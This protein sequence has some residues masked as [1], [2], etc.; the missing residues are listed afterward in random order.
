MQAAGQGWSS[1]VGSDAV[2]TSTSAA[3]VA[4]VPQPSSV[5]LY[6]DMRVAGVSP[7]SSL[8]AVDLQA[9][10]IYRSSVVY[11]QVT[12]LIIMLRDEVTC[13]FSVLMLSVRQQEQLSAVKTR[14]TNSRGLFT[15]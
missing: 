11:Q 3:A 15:W 14:S 6:S 10:A 1:S 7:A 5:Q 4:S 12:T 2:T 9:S 13:L 8:S